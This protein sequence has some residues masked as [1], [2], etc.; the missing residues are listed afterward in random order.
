M[1]PL[2]MLDRKDIT[3]GKTLQVYLGNVPFLVIGEDIR[4]H[5]EMLRKFLQDNGVP[6]VEE[7]LHG[8]NFGPQAIGDRYKL[9]GA[10]YASLYQGLIQLW[11]QSDGY[12]ISSDEKHARE[13]SDLLKDRRVEIQKSEP[14]VSETE[15]SSETKR[16]T[17]KLGDEIPF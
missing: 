1:D 15:S 6:F 17:Q 16:S 5:H 7:P 10:G 12:R 11:G 4:R 2:V 8:P 3:F 9:V 14:V 13:I